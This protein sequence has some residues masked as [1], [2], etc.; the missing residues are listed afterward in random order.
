MSNRQ[1]VYVQ[2]LIE[3]REYYVIDKWRLDNSRR[4]HI[5]YFQGTFVRQYPSYNNSIRAEFSTG[6]SIKVVNSYNEFYLAHPSMH[7][8]LRGAIAR[9]AALISNPKLSL[10][11]MHEIQYNPMF[12]LRQPEHHFSADTIE[13]FVLSKSIP[14]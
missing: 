1:R 8:K 11:Q 5:I 4:P 3:D 13:R 2:D 6:N 14:L 7:P 12:V 10:E 9:R